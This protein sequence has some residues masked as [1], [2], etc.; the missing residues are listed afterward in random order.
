MSDTV[1]TQTTQSDDLTAI[2]GN[3]GADIQVPSADPEGSV[4]ETEIP[5][6]VPEEPGTPEAGEVPAEEGAAEKPAEVA[7]DSPPPVKSVKEQPHIPPAVAKQLRQDRR[8]LQ[9]KLA[10]EQVLRARAEARAELLEELHQKGM[11]SGKPETAQQP[12]VEK[13]PL[14]KFAEEFP[15]EPAPVKVQIDQENWRQQQ[16]AAQ[17]K[18][19]EVESRTLTLTQQ[20]AQG[21][22]KAKEQYS[23]LGE[24]L[25]LDDVVG[26]AKAYKLI[27]QEELEALTPLGVRAGTMAYNLAVDAI[28]TAGGPALAEMARRVAIARSRQ[29]SPM[30][31][32][33]NGTQPKPKSKTN[34][35]P[36]PAGGGTPQDDDGIS[37]LARFICSK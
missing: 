1:Q 4:D 21:I 15:D 23:K 6:E 24:G 18:K 36:A 35:P 22:Q 25:G 19:Q 16:Q 30:K 31:N 37:P 7:E 2:F 32:D 33:V 17:A 12:A 8:D 20:V 5:A 3:L 28:R 34:T 27:S 9:E 11:F 29:A 10:Q 14:E 13:S 26:L